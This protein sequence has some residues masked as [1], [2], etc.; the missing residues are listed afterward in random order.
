MSTCRVSRG[1]RDKVHALSAIMKARQA[2]VARPAR[3]GVDRFTVQEAMRQLFRPGVLGFLALAVVVG[4]WGYGYKLS[5]Y[6]HQS[7]ITHASATRMLPE[8]R[9]GSFLAAAHLLPR[10]HQLQQ[11][12]QRLNLFSAR[13][14]HLTNEFAVYTSTPL[15]PVFLVASLI[16]FRAPPISPSFLV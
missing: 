10:P 4:A 13:V 15:R 5:Q 12:Q 14:P 1:A 6:S 16:P 3:A 8:H 9:N 11:E 7:P 2:D